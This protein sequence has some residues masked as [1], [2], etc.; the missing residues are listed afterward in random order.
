MSLWAIVP[1]KSLRRGKSRLANVLT[2]EERSALNND[3]LIRTLH[4]L[5]SIPAIDQVLVISYDPEVLA[6]ARELGTMTVQEGKRT[7]LNNALRRATVAAKAYN[8]SKAIIIPADLPF[9]NKEDIEDFIAQQGTPP[10]IIISSDQRSDGTNALLTNPIGILEYN[11]G[12]WSFRKHIEQA[13]Q[14]KIN[15]KV[16]NEKS[17]TFD[18]DLPEDLEIFLKASK[19]KK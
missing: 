17:L 8:A 9:I 7:N 2:D 15:V 4:C 10:E 14:K 6:K 1:V 13:E 5:Q 3:L 18:L 16:K 11:F 12:E 19:I